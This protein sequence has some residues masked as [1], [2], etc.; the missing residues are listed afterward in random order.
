M[1]N[2]D[3]I[4]YVNFLTKSYEGVTGL[5]QSTKNRIQSLPG[6]EGNERDLI[7]K[8]TLAFGKKEDGLL[9]IQGRLSRLIAR[10]LPQWDAYEAWLKNV[11]GIGT[12][13]SAKLILLFNYRFVPVCAECGGRLAKDGGSMVCEA[14]GKGSRGDGN[15]KYALEQRDF[16]TVSKWWAFMGRHTVDGVM[17]KRKA[18]AV[19]NWSSAGRVLGFL[20][21]DQFNRQD[22]SHEYKAFFLARKERHRRRHEDWTKGHVHNAAGNE[23]VKLFLSH[24]WHVSRALAGKPTKTCYAE[25]MLG[26]ENIIAPYYWDPAEYGI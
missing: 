9:T 18:G 4:Q 6:A 19:A 16:P 14:C 25:G 15:L 2:Q 21:A 5:I 3:V 26:H 17:P 7:L 1:H 10:E 11:P 20:I 13:I 12:Y 24:F 22:E 8:S 23:T